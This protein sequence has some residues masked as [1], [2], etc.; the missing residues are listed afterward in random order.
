MKLY[1]L[2][3]KEKK[4]LCRGGERLLT[5]PSIPM[6]AISKWDLAGNRLGHHIF[7]MRQQYYLND[8]SNALNDFL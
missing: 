1:L 4:I 2:L 6:V 5:L 7:I 8:Y 3:Y